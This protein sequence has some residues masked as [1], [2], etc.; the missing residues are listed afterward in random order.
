MFSF[1]ALQTVDL[2][3]S[4]SSWSGC[5]DDCSFI[6]QRLDLAETLM[7]DSSFEAKGPLAQLKVDLVYAAV[8]LRW[9]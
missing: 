4:Y 9:S 5:A 6:L 3:Q 7:M 2:L 8:R 1:T